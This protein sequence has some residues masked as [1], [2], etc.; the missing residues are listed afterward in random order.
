MIISSKA[1][2]ISTVASNPGVGLESIPQG[3]LITLIVVIGIL[4]LGAGIFSFFIGK[5]IWKF[6]RWARITAIVLSIIGLISVIA[7][8]ILNFKFMNIISLI[9][10]GF[11]GGYLLF[12]REA[13]EIFKKN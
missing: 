12:S 5:G 2:A 13:K 6:K 11:I 7:S 4:A 1:M 9:I 8:M 3:M 10:D